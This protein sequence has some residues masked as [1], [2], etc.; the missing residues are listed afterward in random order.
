[1][2]TYSP[3]PKV[4]EF[5]AELLSADPNNPYAAVAGGITCVIAMVRERFGDEAARDVRILH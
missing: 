4:H 2:Q 5:V 1:M 3:D